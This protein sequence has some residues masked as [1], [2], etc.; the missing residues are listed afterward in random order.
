MGVAAPHLFVGAEVDVA[1]T[2]LMGDPDLQVRS[3]LPDQPA[4][5][6]AVNTMTYQPGASLSRVE[7]HV[8]EHG[9]LTVSYTHLDVYKRQPTIRR[10]RPR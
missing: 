5:D 9:L 4:F 1:S 2:A 6:F 3:L 8:M 10:A 7:I